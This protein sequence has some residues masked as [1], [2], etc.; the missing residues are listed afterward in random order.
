MAFTLETK[1]HILLIMI[2]IGI[3]L[4]MYLLY[5]EVKVFQ[6]EIVVIKAQIAQMQISTM[7]PSPP[8]P[9]LVQEDEKE[10]KIEH[11]DEE[12]DDSH[13]V[14]SNEIKNILTNIQEKEEVE[15]DNDNDDDDELELTIIKEPAAQISTMTEDELVLQKY[16]VL[17]EYLRGKK[18]SIK[19]TKAELI[20]RILEN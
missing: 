18:K 4:Y 6:D 3:S 1:L 17:R 16:E 10:I 14:T 7:R 20:K 8:L 15:S 9:D 2:V 5:K 12:E 13:S 19:G 11:E